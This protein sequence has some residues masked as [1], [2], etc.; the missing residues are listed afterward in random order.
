[1]EIK[2]DPVEETDEYKAVVDDV[3]QMAEALVNQDIRYGRFHFVE[4]EKKR[5]LKEKYNID[6]KTT[7][8]MNPTWDFI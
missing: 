2:H 5:I 4:L 7:E 8:E 3:E 6:W 1:M